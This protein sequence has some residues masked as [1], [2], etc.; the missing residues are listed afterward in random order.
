M[1]FFSVTVKLVAM[2]KYSSYI[3]SDLL[4]SVYFAHFVT[5]FRFILALDCS[6]AYSITHD[7]QSLIEMND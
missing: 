7:D 2:S 5:T 3:E 6:R 1:F 4:M